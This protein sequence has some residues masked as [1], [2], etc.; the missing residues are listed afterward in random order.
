VGVTLAEGE[1]GEAIVSNIVHY[2]EDDPGAVGIGHIWLKPIAGPF[3]SGM[4]MFFRNADNT[5]WI[6]PVGSSVQGGA[7]SRLANEQAVMLSGDVEAPE[8]RTELG[9][10]PKS[11]VLVA[12]QEGEEPLG[13]VIASGGLGTPRGVELM[14]LPTSNP[15]V[16]GYLWN[17]NGTLKIS[18]G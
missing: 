2:G 1:S 15:N 12:R 11:A 10:F 17:D 7:A 9:I 5:A 14:G 8:N 18:A 16:A 13:M 6:A 4:T 3:V